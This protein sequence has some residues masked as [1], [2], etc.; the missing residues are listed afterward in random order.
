M[1]IDETTVAVITG[2]ASGIGYAIAEAVLAR[3]GRV[4]LS[5]V[6][7]EALALA[8]DRLR[9]GSGEVVGVVADVS[10]AGSV[11]SLASAAV[12]RFGEVNLVCNNAGVLPPAGPMWEQDLMT[13]QR[14]INI[15]VMGVI[16][17]VR[18]FAPLLIAQGKGHILNTA[19]SSALTPL[20]QRT[21][22][23]GTMH[24]VVG[25][26]E[27]LDL[28]LKG[29][30]PALGATVLCPGLVDTALGQ[31]SAELGS[32][33]PPAG[34]ARTIGAMAPG[35][36]SPRTVADCAIAAIEAQRVHSAPGEG[37]LV[38]AQRRVTVMLADLLAEDNAAVERQS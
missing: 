38:R 4:V 26:T 17:G 21:P 1:K 6:R 2:G 23:T 7:Q 12:G 30:N 9:E 22:Y 31:N 3:G 24:A 15:K 35:A 32:I 18:T 28:E 27:T 16:H 14:M 36:L 29:E 25:L 34:P 37:V 5:D 33:K 13:W 11:D 19:S 20:P 8:A 10:D